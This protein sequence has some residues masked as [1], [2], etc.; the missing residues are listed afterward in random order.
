MKCGNLKMFVEIP[1]F[2]YRDVIEH[3]KF[4][5]FRM[6]NNFHLY[7]KIANFQF[8]FEKFVEIMLTMDVEG[9]TKSFGKKCHSVCR[10]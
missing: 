3:K 10:Q 4:L 6:P 1:I 8:S 2:L 5:C 7:C 9:T